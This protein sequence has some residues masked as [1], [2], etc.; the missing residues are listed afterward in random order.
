MSMETSLASGKKAVVRPLH[1]MVLVQML[2]AEEKIG[3]III[4]TGSQE[5]RK[6]GIVIAK[7]PGKY[8]EFTASSSPMP[9]NVKDRVLFGKWAG[10]DLKQDGRDLM[11]V[12]VEDILAILEE[13]EIPAAKA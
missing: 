13:V 6:Q 5:R 3:S 2:P 9:I 1:D 8:N 10:T 12:K 11:L 4:P 7:G